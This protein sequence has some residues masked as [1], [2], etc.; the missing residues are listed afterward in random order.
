MWLID[1]WGA[2]PVALGAGAASSLLYERGRR[3]LA[4]APPA[5][6][7]WLVRGGAAV[8]LITVCSPLGYWSGLDASARAT[9]DVL[10]AYLAAPLVVLGAPWLPWA[11]GMG[12]GG[13]ERLE[14]WLARRRG[15][16]AWSVVSSPAFALVMFLL[17]FTVW[18]VPSVFDAGARSGAVRGA[19]LAA[20]FLA[21]MLLW[22]QVVGSRPFTPRLGLASR[23][24][25]L[26]AWLA[27]TFVVGVAMVFSNTAWYP[28]YDHVR[29]AYLSAVADQSITGGVIWVLPAIS[30]SV[31]L[32]WVL[33]AWLNR[34]NDDD[35]HLARL[36]EDTRSRMTGAGH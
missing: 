36:I 24:W 19:G 8:A 11:A 15:T 1:H 21:T 3:R 7:S 16:R 29:G 18:W 32:F 33:V 10:L 26:L 14:R 34:D 2:P 20:S 30:L 13:E 25:V 28:A 9:E 27:V 31:V 6:Q 23:A 12:R 22:G 5:G 4:Q 17:L 35:W